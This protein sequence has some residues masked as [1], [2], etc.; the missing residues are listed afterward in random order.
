[1]KREELRKLRQWQDRLET[2]K[3]AIQPELD[4]MG[5]RES[6]YDG[7]P[8]IYRPDGAKAEAGRASHVRNV[9]FELVEAQVESDIPTPKVTA[10]RQ[11]D[12]HLADVVENL[13]RNVIDKL[14]FERLNDE[15]ERISP[16][17]GGHGLLV[18]WQ[19][20]ISGKDWMGDL[21]VTMMHPRGIIPQAN[22]SQVADMDWIFLESPA[23]RRQIRDAFGV[24]LEENENESDARRLG[25]SPDNSGEIVTLVTCYFRNGKG[26]IG[27][28]RWVNDTVVEDLEDYQV[29]RVQKCAA[30]G[31]SDCPFRKEPQA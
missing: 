7:D 26:G 30:C 17:Q 3:E 25:D 29:R 9:A 4:R 2:A 23:T 19:D 28:Y 27:R 12:E 18:D 24:A 6:I 15:G 16:V 11:E 20:G 10:I 1:M 8:T 21:R 5:K 22:V 13:L 31:A 14:P